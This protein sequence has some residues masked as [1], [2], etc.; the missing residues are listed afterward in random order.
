MKLRLWEPF[1]R[2]RP[3]TKEWE[4][5]INEASK[6]MSPREGLDNATWTPKVDVVENE[7]SYVVNAD[8]PG[9][10]KED[11]KIDIDD[12]TLTI[13]GEKKLENKE[14]KENYIR[15][16]R[17]YGSFFRTFALSENVDRENIKANY[18]D[19]VLELTL[20]KKE[21]AKPKQIEVEVN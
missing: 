12:N 13:K 11:I 6:A 9:M 17:S 21:E 8:I 20:P 15:I 18:K 16:E 14:E 7:D 3:F 1:E 5:W 19:G 2:V 10:N 4:E